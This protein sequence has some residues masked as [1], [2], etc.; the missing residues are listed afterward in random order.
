M[1]RLTGRKERLERLEVERKRYG[2]WRQKCLAALRKGGKCFGADRVAAFTLNSFIIKFQ[3]FPPVP[4]Q[5]GV[6]I[7]PLSERLP[8]YFTVQYKDVC[9]RLMLGCPPSPQPPLPPALI[10]LQLTGDQ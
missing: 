1:F 3:P 4:Q 2:V 8:Q 7:F 5:A 6:C 9:V 10:T